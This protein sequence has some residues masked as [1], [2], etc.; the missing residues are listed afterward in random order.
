VL[1]V[2]QIVSQRVLLCLSSKLVKQPPAVAALVAPHQH[3]TPSLG[4]LR[5]TQRHSHSHSPY[6]SCR[7][8]FKDTATG[9]GAPEAM[10]FII[11]ICTIV[12]S[13]SHHS[14]CRSHY[15]AWASCAQRKDTATVA[16]RSLVGMPG[17]VPKHLV[18]KVSWIQHPCCNC[19]AMPRKPQTCAQLIQ[20][21]LATT[22][23]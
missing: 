12:D 9:L 7:S 4:F 5:S 15:K 1:F 22:C 19:L 8:H 17:Q 10:P 13:D 23:Q 14:S 20:H 18:R 2:Q 6:S 16:F 11:C 21:W 3:S